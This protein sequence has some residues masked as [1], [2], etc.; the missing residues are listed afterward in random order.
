MLGPTR[1]RGR[2]AL[3]LLALLA[4]LIAGLVLLGRALLPG[5]VKSRTLAALRGGLGESVTLS[6]VDLSLSQSQIT[7]R[8]FALPA[9]EGYAEET[10]LAFEALRIDVES[11]WHALR[12]EMQIQ[13]VTLVGPHVVVETDADERMNLSAILNREGRT[14]AGE[15]THLP[16]IQ[17]FLIERGTLV[18]HDG[19]LDPPLVTPIEEIGTELHGLGPLI[20]N[21]VG[22][23][24]CDLRG[25]ALGESPLALQLEASLPDPHRVNIDWTLTVEDLDVTHFQPHWSEASALEIVRGRADACLEGV[26][27]RGQLTGSLTLTFHEFETRINERPGSQ[28]LGL[29]PQAVASFFYSEHAREPLV[30]PLRGDMTDPEFDLATAIRAAVHDGLNRRISQLVDSGVLVVRSAG[31]LGAGVVGGVLDIAEQ[32][33]VAGAAV[34]EGRGIGAGLLGEVRDLG[35]GVIREAGELMERDSSP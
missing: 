3:R 27:R 1:R 24:S 35:Q 15:V 13:E 21:G 31:E 5:Y 14:D 26:C 34:E 2:W 9:P 8:G 20:E 16:P 11:L 28:A 25:I 30:I 4:L 23:L 19:T 22:D 12:G 18:W 7:L 33:P 10:M 29:A 32:I 17:R 6:E